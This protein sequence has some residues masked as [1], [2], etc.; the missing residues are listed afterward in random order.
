MF[1]FVLKCFF[2]QSFWVQD[3]INSTISNLQLKAFSLSIVEIWNKSLLLPCLSQKDKT[4]ILAIFSGILTTNLL[5]CTQPAVMIR[6]ILILFV[7]LIN[8]TWTKVFYLDKFLLNFFLIFCYF[9]FKLKK[10]LE[11][12]SI[13]FSNWWYKLM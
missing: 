10:H 11:K 4:S 13:Y 2:S 5:L 8:K 7:S 1:A 9:Y 3:Q 12:R 6:Y